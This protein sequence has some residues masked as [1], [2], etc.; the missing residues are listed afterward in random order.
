MWRQP[1]SRQPS[2]TPPAVLTVRTHVHLCGGSSWG[3]ELTQNKTF[4]KQHNL[5][6]KI[7]CGAE[8]WG[9]RR[10][11][12]RRA[13]REPTDSTQPRTSSREPSHRP[14]VDN[15]WTEAGYKQRAWFTAELSPS[16][17]NLESSSRGTQLSDSSPG[18]WT[19]WAYKVKG[20][21][22]HARGWGGTT[23][24]EGFVTPRMGLSAVPGL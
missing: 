13:S 6:Q 17:P 20:A 7:L 5:V 1:Q 12:P 22:A 3:S 21:T 8:K 19:S 11:A 16:L 4:R 9:T 18:P 2:H 10:S 15:C 23:R 14:R 24:D